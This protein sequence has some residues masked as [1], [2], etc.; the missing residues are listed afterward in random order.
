M[1]IP[2]WIFAMRIKHFET[3]PQK[4][5]HHTAELVQPPPAQFSGRKAALAFIAA[6]PHTTK[7]GRW[8]WINGFIPPD[9]RRRQWEKETESLG[10]FGPV[11]DDTVEAGNQGRLCSKY[12]HTLMADVKRAQKEVG[13]LAALNEYQMTTGLV[14]SQSSATTTA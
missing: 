14:K 8:D 12:E 7:A 11:T 2:P 10:L 13:F 4:D 9:A 5:A 1:R 3:M 6:L